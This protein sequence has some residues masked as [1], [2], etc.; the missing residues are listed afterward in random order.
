VRTKLDLMVAMLAC[1]MT[2]GC[3]GKTNESSYAPAEPGGAGLA[4]SAPDVG[5]VAAKPGGEPSS[6]R[7][8]HFEPVPIAAG[9]EMGEA[10]A[11]G[12]STTAASSPAAPGVPPHC[13]GRPTSVV[14]IAANLDSA[15][16]AINTAGIVGPPAIAPNPFD[17]QNPANSANF[18]TTLTV[19]DSRGTA[20][21]MDVY[22]RKS[23]TEVNTWDYHL[24]L[25][26]ADVVGGA[27]GMNAE[28]GNGGTLVF[29]G[30]GAL[31][32][33]IGTTANIDFVDTRA[34]QT[35][36]FDFGQPMVAG[37]SGLDGVTDLPGSSNVSRQAQD[38]VPAGPG[39]NCGSS[40]GA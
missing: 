24:L 37:D 7:M 31:Q 40:D 3:G 38:G 15:A 23:D 28:V 13:S 22:F 39:S 35:I 18:S 20:H 29:S 26:G 12:A 36:T 5:L 16:T 8:P 19:Y 11:A 9:A 1:A 10:G 25:P 17:P 30:N 32:T 27:P 6:P 34:G 4:G 2:G 21:S 14:T 33:V